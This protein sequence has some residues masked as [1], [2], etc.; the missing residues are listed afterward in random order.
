MTSGRP[1]EQ[2]P[3]IWSPSRPTVTNTGSELN[4]VGGE[5]DVQNPKPTTFTVAGFQQRLEYQGAPTGAWTPFARVVYDASGNLVPETPQTA[6]IQIPLGFF[7]FGNSSGA[8]YPQSGNSIVGTTIASGGNGHWAWGADL[9][10][11]ADVT[12][13]LFDPEQSSGLRSVFSFDVP[14]GSPQ[15][16]TVGVDYPGF[17]A[18]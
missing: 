18:I 10:V 15:A 14:S 4:F 6:L 7:P 13:I 3:A 12:A 9:I 1:V 8:T 5:L 11:P 17:T 16:S 2:S